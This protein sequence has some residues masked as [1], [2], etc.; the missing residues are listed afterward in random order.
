MLHIYVTYITN[1]PHPHMTQQSPLA[2]THLRFFSYYAKVDVHNCTGVVCCFCWRLST[3]PEMTPTEVIIVQALNLHH[4]TNKYAA[5][6]RTLCQDVGKMQFLQ[7]CKYRNMI[8]VTFT[9]LYV[10]FRTGFANSYL[11]RHLELSG[12][13]YREVCRK[14]I[15]A[16]RPRF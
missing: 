10:V 3:A 5:S 7:F 2:P 4:S 6:Q 12:I 15:P 9:V 11:H 14:T 16:P 8:W 13:K 1:P